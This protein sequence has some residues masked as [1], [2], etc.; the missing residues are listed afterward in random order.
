M[1][2]EKEISSDVPAKVEGNE[3]SV[4][5]R[6]DFREFM[7]ELIGRGPAEGIFTVS[8]N[9]VE[10]PI[11]KIKEFYTEVFEKIFEETSSEEVKSHCV[12]VIE[13]IAND[14][15]VADIGRDCGEALGSICEGV[16]GEGIGDI[17]AELLGGLGEFFN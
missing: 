17:C 16:D 11:D 5:Y 2:L 7:I 1:K 10:A 15:N 8:S 12:D 13:K 3:P 4:E 6:T 14:D 9:L